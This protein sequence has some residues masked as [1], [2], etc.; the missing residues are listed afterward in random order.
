MRSSQAMMTAEMRHHMVEEAAYYRA[1]RRDFSP[2]GELADWLEAEAE[3]DEMF[4]AAEGDEMSGEEE[5]IGSQE[6]GPKSI[7]RQDK[8]ERL[9]KEH[10]Q[11]DEP[12]RDSVEPDERRGQ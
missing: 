3:V 11:R 1:Q 8:L 9:V 2:G 5:R 12:R 4:A 10:P 7:A 6:G